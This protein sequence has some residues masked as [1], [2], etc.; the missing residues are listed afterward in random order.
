MLSI[1][2]VRLKRKAGQHG[3]FASSL[4]QDDLD[5]KLFGHF[6]VVSC[7]PTAAQG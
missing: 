7:Q 1:A 4:I 2:A 5:V 6:L 3:L